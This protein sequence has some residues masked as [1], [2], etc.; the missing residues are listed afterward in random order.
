MKKI[1]FVIF[2]MAMILGCA[3]EKATIKSADIS[4]AVNHSLLSEVYI[5]SEIGISFYPPSNW[6][7][8]SSELLI[9][10]K[11]NINA[12]AE[13][14]KFSIVP[15]NVF[16]DMEKSSTCFFSTFDNELPADDLKE[17]YLN[18]LRV[19]ND[20]LIINEGSFV[21][22]GLDFHQL[23]F[24]KDDLIT[25]KLIA[26]TK[27]QKVLMIDY[28]LPTKYYEEELRTIESSIGTIKKTKNEIGL[29]DITDS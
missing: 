24:T 9:A 4:F 22:N 17:G 23:T 11:K 18:E 5:C 12:S 26:T 8:I 21:H 15:L 7:Q 10:I 28:I 27:D 29:P 1:I 20:D 19:Q 13:T 3:K 16:M 25:I 6:K 14:T 2:I